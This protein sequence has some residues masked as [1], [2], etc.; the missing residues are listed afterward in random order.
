M[1]AKKRCV[2]IKD[3]LSG[4]IFKQVKLANVNRKHQTNISILLDD[5]IDVSRNVLTDGLG[6]LL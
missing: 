5:R 3:S 2:T 1:A 4:D 6:R